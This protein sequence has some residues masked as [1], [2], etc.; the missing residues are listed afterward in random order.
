VIWAAILLAAPGLKIDT[1]PDIGPSFP[2]V[3]VVMAKEALDTPKKAPRFG[4]EFP[5]LVTGLGDLDAPAPRFR[6]FSQDEQS[7]REVAPAVARM[8][9]RLWQFNYAGFGLDHAYRYNRRLIDVYL[10]EQGDPGGEQFFAYDP[11]VR[12]DV[13]V[14][15]IYDLKSF[16][17]PVEKA[18]EVAHEYGHATLPP[19]GGYGNG[20]PW[21]NGDA[22]EV[23]YMR[24]VRD[25]LKS[26]R[27]TPADAM[28]ADLGGVDSWVRQNADPLMIK[29]ATHPP[30]AIASKTE[31]GRDAYL[32]WMLY[33]SALVPADI[34]RRIVK[35][36]P[37]TDAKDIP[38]TVLDAIGEN[39]SPISLLAPPQLAGRTIWI[40]VGR[41]S[42]SGATVLGKRAGWAKVRLGGSLR[43]RLSSGTR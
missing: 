1:L 14:I 21:A 17:D 25:A 5:Y 7:Q 22:G 40:P 20:E 31:D 34:W 39:D 29:A 26:G 13:D 6:V 16:T 37:T 38:G 12:A 33:L 4:S 32:G 11:D 42:L 28:G 15:F 18:R 27:L 43:L 19:I 36:T 9:L 41:R 3:E 2:P 10:C 23:L 8:L 35:L 24:A 30:Q